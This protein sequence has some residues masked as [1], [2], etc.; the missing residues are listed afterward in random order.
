MGA[1]VQKLNLK[2]ALLA[3]VPLTLLACCLVQSQLTSA[4]LEEPAYLA[5]PELSS[6]LRQA[7]TKKLSERKEILNR[8]RL[9]AKSQK[10]RQ[11]ISY[12]LARLLKKCASKDELKE[13]IPLFEEASGLPDLSHRCFL[14]ISEC[15]NTLGDENKVQE[16]LHKLETGA[17][18]PLLKA[19]AQYNLAQSYLR[20]NETTKARELFL[21]L[22]KKF[23]DSQ[24]ALGAQYYLG[25]ASLNDNDRPACLSFWRSYL[26]KSPDG[27]FA[28]DIVNSWQNQK[29]E[30]AASDH[31][32][33]AR[34][35]F[36]CGQ[37]SKAINEWKLQD[38]DNDWFKQG[39]ALIRSSKGKE[40]KE[41]LA[42]AL[43]KHNTSTEVPEAAKLLARL[44]SKQEAI[45]IWSLVLSKCPNFADAALY[46]LAI[47]AP[48]EEALKYY[49]EL[50]SKYPDS[51][52]APESAWWLVWHKI[53][54][55]KTEAAL[56]LLR[57]SAA[58]YEK[59]RAGSRFS[60]WIGKLEERLKNKSAAQNAY[61]ETAAKYPSHYYG[62]RA[63][64]RLSFLKGESDPGWQRTEKADI[65]SYA[66][67]TDWSPPEPPYLIP[68]QSIAKAGTSTLACLSELRQWDECLELSPAEKIPELKSLCLAK[69]NLPL[70]SINL[71]A[72]E[73]QGK[74]EKTPRWQLAYPL[75]HA[76]TI[77]AE[78]RAKDVDPF[79]AQ[80]L[81][82]E[83]SRY[84]VY[85]LSS[86]NAIGLMQ[87]LPSTA[88]GVAKRLGVK[89][90]SHDDI[91]K[92]ENNIKLGIDYM[93]YV[94]KR[95]QG[96]RMLAVASY[97]G[98]PNAVSAWTKTYSLQDP[99]AFVENIPYN[100]TR[101][102]V[103]KVFGSYWNYEAIYGRNLAKV[104]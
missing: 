99:D 13:A 39:Q 17:K 26:E 6:L 49:G 85:A 32:Q 101:D 55:G 15:A 82:R 50:L 41:F 28:L 52:F 62:F 48:Q 74:P 58:K 36:A 18:D 95:C 24:Y 53:K 29:F 5:D 78:S 63:L 67:Q 2:A 87:L 60:F 23:P 92:P 51:D 77:L 37:W 65:D 46:N 90:G 8:L 43:V 33:F 25:Q 98:G 91:H 56:S 80:A 70:E 71:M 22:L 86:S 100:E 42:E 81:I 102:Y 66:S 47:R 20:A 73:L 69:L 79:L 75:L 103:R 3:S 83:E 14:H 34:V 45:S 11:K 12:V 31:L 93:S 16:S 94:I 27:R 4:K 54:E 72:R 88:M 7:E 44:G 1:E 76:K 61:A 57:Q 104:K 35:Y 10:R 89:I 9:A 64:S 96:N 97:N 21:A 38:A 30:S 68:Y 19:Q 84:N 59:A 40:G